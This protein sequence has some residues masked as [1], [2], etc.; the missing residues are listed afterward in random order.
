[1][2]LVE[3]ALFGG[4]HLF[5][6]LGDRRIFGLKARFEYASQRIGSGRFSSTWSSRCTSPNP[7]PLGEVDEVTLVEVHH[8]IGVLRLQVVEDRSDSVFEL[9][10][11]RGVKRPL[12]RFRRLIGSNS[13]TRPPSRRTWL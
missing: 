9:L 2:G 3:R 7:S 12:N 5:H 1:M 11:I 10:H 8:R 4:Q 6:R 13:E